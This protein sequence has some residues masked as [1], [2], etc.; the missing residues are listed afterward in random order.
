M[1]VLHAA[2]HAAEGMAG[3]AVAASGTCSVAVAPALWPNVFVGVHL[4]WPGP[5]CVLC[6]QGG[7]PRLGLATVGGH[8]WA[9]V[10]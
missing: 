9:L 10:T 4:D 1:R 2:W 3:C 6:V 7:S 8:D 5:I